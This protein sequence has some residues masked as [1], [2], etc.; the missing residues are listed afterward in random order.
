MKSNLN[1]KIDKI[2]PRGSFRRNVVTLMS[3]TALAQLITIATTPILS[4]IYNPSD[5]GLLGLFTSLALIFSTISSLRY[6]QAILLPKEE[7]EAIALTKLATLIVFL[8]SSSF[9]IFL[10]PYATEFSSLLKAPSFKKIVFLLPF[11]IAALGIY[12]VLNYWSSRNKKFKILAISR[13]TQSA[14]SSLYQISAGYFMANSFNLV[15]GQLIG[16]IA[17]LINLLF[18]ISIKEK[19]KFLYRAP[20]K[21]YKELLVKYR[22]FPF[23]STIA[24]LINTFSAQVPTILLF[25][26]FPSQTVGYFTLSQKIISMPIAL[27]SNT[28]SQVYYQDAAKKYHQSRDKMKASF[29]KTF[30]FLF[31]IGSLISVVLIFSPAIFRFV[32]GKRWIE[33][34]VYAQY[35]S[36]FLPIQ[37]GVAA[38]SPVINVLRKQK[39]N[40]LWQALRFALSS[41]G[42]IIGGICN[43]ARLSILLFCVANLLSYLLLFVVLFYYLTELAK[44][45]Q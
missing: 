28:T 10:F 39:V 5:F 4:R 38:V 45:N 21:K 9:L 31:L 16:Q 22:E 32:L 2:F 23:F 24:A 14:S 44:S 25:Q 27:I 36:L 17:A 43:D 35:M 20:L 41:M 18:Q 26:F 19:S 7:K 33:A 15:F 6:E 12:Q 13:F 30:G 29:L 40:L 3:G 37:F 1:N 42:I 11:S 34:G 8:F